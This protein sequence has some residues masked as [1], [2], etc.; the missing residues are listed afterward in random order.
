[1]AYSLG[2]EEQTRKKQKMGWE[3]DKEREW[4]SSP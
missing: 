1:M 2:K 4:L 3:K